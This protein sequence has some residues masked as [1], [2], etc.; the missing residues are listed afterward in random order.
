MRVLHNVKSTLCKTRP[1]HACMPTSTGTPSMLRCQDLRIS[2]N[3]CFSAALTGN[4]GPCKENQCFVAWISSIAAHSMALECQSLSTDFE[5]S[6]SGFAGN[7]LHWRGRL[8]EAGPK[9]DLDMQDGIAYHMGCACAECHPLWPD[10]WTSRIPQAPSMACEI[11]APPLPQ[12]TA[13]YD[14]MA[15]SA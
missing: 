7:M 2:L 3:A 6:S 5:G 15:I 13:C 14:V 12:I 11:C 4:W 9:G 8:A 10:L 1:D